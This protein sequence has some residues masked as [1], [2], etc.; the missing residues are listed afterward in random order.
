M[1][2]C[3]RISMD[4][5]V[6]AHRCIYGS[7]YFC[8]CVSIYVSMHLCVGVYLCLYACMYTCMCR[9]SYASMYLC[10]HGSMRLSIYVSMYRC[11]CGPI[12]S[13]IYV[14]VHRCIYVDVYMCLD[15]SVYLCIRAS[16]CG[17][18]RRRLPT[19]R[20]APWKSEV[21]ERP[22]R[23]H[24]RAAVAA[25][26]GVRTC[27]NGVGGGGEGFP[28][29]AERRGSRRLVEGLG[30]RRERHRALGSRMRRADLRM[31]GGRKLVCRGPLCC[32]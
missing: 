24:A 15:V 11:I 25:A 32:R 7:M 22:W 6:S 8:T 1:C 9:C 28:H 2:L 18:R 13:C 19:W 5:Y 26:V 16:M 21:C 3:L 30:A 14:S 31:V 29:A 17:T 12:H 20:G 4:L 23:T 27:A 10:I